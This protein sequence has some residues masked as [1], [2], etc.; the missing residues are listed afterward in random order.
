MEL[1]WSSSSTKILTSC[2]LSCV[3][4]VKPPNLIKSRVK[5]EKLTIS[6][7]NQNDEVVF[8]KDCEGLKNILL[9]GGGKVCF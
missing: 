2:F 8:V 7:L 5:I 1:D 4:K 6:F 3:E 9:V